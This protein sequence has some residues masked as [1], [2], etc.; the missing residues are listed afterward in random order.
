MRIGLEL[1]EYETRLN[2]VCPGSES[3]R[4]AVHLSLLLC[5]LLML[6]IVFPFLVNL[7]LQPLALGLSLNLSSCLSSW[8]CGLLLS[9]AASN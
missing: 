6:T 7:F 1:I 9:L 8:C 2:F 3:E 5:S 4:Q